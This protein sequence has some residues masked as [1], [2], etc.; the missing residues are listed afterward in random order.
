MT[1]LESNIYVF[2]VLPLIFILIWSYAFFYNRRISHRIHEME[3]PGGHLDS[4]EAGISAAM[5]RTAQTARIR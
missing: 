5:H 4:M 1:E 3:G 2:G